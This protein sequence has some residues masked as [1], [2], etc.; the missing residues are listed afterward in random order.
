MSTSDTILDA[1]KMTKGTHRRILKKVNYQVIKLDR[2]KMDKCDNS[3]LTQFFFG[4]G[5]G[6]RKIFTLDIFYTKNIY[7]YRT[8]KYLQP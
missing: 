6:T 7:I 4:G 8:Q 5:S 3:R 2:Q 1:G